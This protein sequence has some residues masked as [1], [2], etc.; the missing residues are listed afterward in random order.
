MRIREMRY[1]GV[2]IWPPHWSCSK[3]AIKENAILKDVKAILGTDLLR[4]DVEHNGIPHLGIMIVEKEA[5]ESLYHKLRESVGR[6]VAEIPDL[7]IEID[8]ETV[9]SCAM[10]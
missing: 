7:E 2:H 4:I 5:R 10:G 1:L 8:Q 3:L 6:Q 9:G